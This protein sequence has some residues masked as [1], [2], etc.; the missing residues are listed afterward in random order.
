MSSFHDFVVM[1]CS[2]EGGHFAF[3]FYYVKLLVS[4]LVDSKPCFLGSSGVA[5]HL[6]VLATLFSSWQ[7]GVFAMPYI[8]ISVT[9]NRLSCV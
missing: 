3:Q 6:V 4:H 5:N 1:Y 9:M 8:V 2:R 7:N